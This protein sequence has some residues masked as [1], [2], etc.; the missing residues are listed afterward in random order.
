MGNP[1]ADA[2]ICFSIPV[3]RS[4]INWLKYPP[5]SVMLSGMGKRDG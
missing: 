2:S 5:I 4:F 3:S 1:K